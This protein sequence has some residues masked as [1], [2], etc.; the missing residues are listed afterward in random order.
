[1]SR[2][3]N[4]TIVSPVRKTFEWS[5][6]LGAFKYYDRNS[7]EE[8]KNVEQPLPFR[9][10]VLDKL[11]T[12]K[13]FSDADK[14]GFWSNEVKDTRTQKLYV[15]T[16]KGL[17]AEGLYAEIKD[18]IVA[19]GARYATQLYVAYYEEKELT[20]GCVTLVGAANSAFIDFQKDN[21][22]FKGAIEVKDFTAAKKGATKYKIPNFTKIE[23]SEAAENKSIELDKEVQ[24]YL[25]AMLQKYNQPPAETRKPEN[26]NGNTVIHADEIPT[27][28][29]PTNDNSDL[30]F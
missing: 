13:G 6:E 18:K 22:I 1:M 7:T 15:R 24:L 28:T 14:S 27:L 20:I 12:I 21:N 17:T 4:D 11:T 10:M 2:S 3:Q 8:N 16:K 26:D 30:P 23:V 5:S 9:F 25:S 29:Q 19:Q